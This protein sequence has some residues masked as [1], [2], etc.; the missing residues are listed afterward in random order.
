MVADWEM[1]RRGE[2]CAA[3]DAVFDAG[4]VMHAC[5]FV[6]TAGYERRDYCTS[7]G[8][9]GDTPPVAEWRTRRQ[10]PEKPRRAFDRDTIIAFFQRL[11]EPQSPEQL[12][13]RFVLALLLWRKKILQLVETEPGA[14]GEIWRFRAPADNTRYDVVRP[15]LDDDRAEALSSQIEQLLSGEQ[16]E[17]LPAGAADDAGEPDAG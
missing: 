16:A 17:L 3:C 2:R 12:Q 15:E 13:L 6:T 14:D 4:T 1:P 10:A 8:P 5:L 11:T 7:C 9:S